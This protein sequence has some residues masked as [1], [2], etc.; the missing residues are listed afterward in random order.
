MLLHLVDATSENPVDDY[1]VIINEL[2]MY[3]GDLADKQRI[4]ALNKIDALTDDERDDIAKALE[5]ATGGPVLRQS[6]VSREGLD[7]TLRVL[8]KIIDANAAAE[9]DAD[10]EPEAWRP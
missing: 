2:E 4:T 5:D 1:K 3:G 6:G 10:K 7:N 9:I 8:R